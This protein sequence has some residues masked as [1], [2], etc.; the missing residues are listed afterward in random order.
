MRFMIPLLSCA[1][2]AA[3]GSAD[4]AD[5]NDTGPKVTRTFTLS[6]F[7]AVAL[8]GSD[9]VRVLNGAAFSV[10]AVGSEKALAELE[11]SVENGTLN[12]KR[13]GR[14]FGWSGDHGAVVTVT[15]PVIRSAALAGSGD[16]SI[17]VTAEDKFD[18][19]LGGSGDMTIAN[20]RAPKIAMSLAG[21]GDLTA[22]GTTQDAAYSVA[23]SGDLSVAK[24]LSKTA[25]I[26]VVG[27]GDVAAHASQAADISL[28]G[29]GNVR[30][31]GT[32]D[33]KISKLGSGDVTCD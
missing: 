13:K 19:V 32:N 9:D 2:L 16:M 18:A 14:S 30:I 3:C 23:G 21:S 33:C 28:V 24:L 4:G 7:D 29:S 17:D 20:V 15:M 25:K 10:T 11:L 12:V 31:T 6:D 8:K 27:S 5:R 26:S 1:M 22:A